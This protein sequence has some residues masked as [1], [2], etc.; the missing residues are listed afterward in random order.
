MAFSLVERGERERPPP[1][2]G[3]YWLTREARFEKREELGLAKCM[4]LAS[5]PGFE[6]GKSLRLG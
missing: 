2:G 5:S 1:V 6:V 4:D 3:F